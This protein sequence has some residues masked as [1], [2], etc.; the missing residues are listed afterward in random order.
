MSGH[1]KWANIKHK[2]A[3]TDAKKG[4]VFSRLAKEIMV[5]AKM[6]GGDAD[7]NP[8]LRAALLAARAVN[9]P[10]ANLERA[11]KKGIGELGD[12]TFEEIVYEG[13]AA[14]G[15]AL[16]IECLTDNR[17]RSISDVRS[18]LDRNCG[19]LGASGAVAWMFKRMCH[20]I[21]TGE[22]AD[23][24]KLMDL[25]LDAGVE[26]IS[27]EDG[28]AELWGPPDKF[29]EIMK[30]LNDAGIQPETAELTRRADT[31]VEITDPK[32]AEQV[33]RLVDRLE[34]LDD[35]QSVSGNYEIADEIAE[36]IAEEE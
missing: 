24:E 1:S 34:D 28:E 30:A 6:G 36:Q 33:L 8:R 22:N 7:A 2:K 14:G 9:M 18:T 11:I 4:R 35:V 5:A 19:N 3:A 17:N 10:N 12:V 20:F 25:T 15:V 27:V 32:I 29:L 31:T 16:I 13:Y 26:D 21:V 23:E